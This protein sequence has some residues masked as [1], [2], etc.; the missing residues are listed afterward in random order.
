MHAVHTNNS[1]HRINCNTAEPV[2]CNAAT[3]LLRCKQTISS[4]L[5]STSLELDIAC[6]AGLP[7][8]TSSSSW[9]TL[10]M[11]LE[12]LLAGCTALKAALK[13]NDGLTELDLT[14]CN[15]LNVEEVAEVVRTARNIKRLGSCN[16]NH[17]GHSRISSARAASAWMAA[18]EAIFG[19]HVQ[20]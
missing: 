15:I 8:Q 7:S 14:G 18:I 17:L 4:K 16:Q 13:H 3:A 5:Q 2:T 6:C 19:W 20:R 10:L 12:H 1:S 9:S 11:L